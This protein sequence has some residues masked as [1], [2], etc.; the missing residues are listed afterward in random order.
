M[1]TTKV[2][3]TA[4]IVWSATVP[5]Q[6][7]KNDLG[8]S[9][10]MTYMSKLMDKGG[11]YYGQ[12][13]G[14]LETIDLDLYDSGFGVAVGHRA[15]TSSGYQ[16]KERYDYKI[17]YGT[18]LFTDETFETRT[19]AAWIYHEHPNGGAQFSDFYEWE[20]ALAWP[21]L[22]SGGWVP[23]YKAC[24]E[25]A[26]G[27]GLSSARWWHVLSLGKDL[28]W[29]PLPN[30]LKLY[31]DVAYRDGLGGIREWTHAT[32]GASTEV[33]LADNLCVVPGVYHQFSMSD[34]LTKDDVT[35]AVIS[36]YYRH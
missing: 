33:A 4:V 9:L 21:N 6:A 15:A 12:Q 19:G 23:G 17:H 32:I 3:L 25:H 7:E 35:Y 2:L 14:L 31:A 36:M 34:Q 28:H 26:L 1:T 18:S 30:P 20:L 29:E 22:I 10:D 16:A 27:T 24:G 11:E 8:F 13:G 5:V